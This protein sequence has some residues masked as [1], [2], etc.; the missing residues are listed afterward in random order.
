MYL[1]QSDTV[2][3]QRCACGCDL[4]MTQ[5]IERRAAGTATPS[6]QHLAA[7]DTSTLAVRGGC[8]GP[9]IAG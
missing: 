1:Q 6:E 7:L 2:T 4:A 8:W 5:Q 9:L 3:G